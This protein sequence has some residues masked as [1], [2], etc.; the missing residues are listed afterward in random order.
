VRGTAWTSAQSGALAQA[1]EET[2][3][4]KE[5]DPAFKAHALQ[6]PVEQQIARDLGSS[7]DPDRIR[8]VRRQLVREIVARNRPALER[9]YLTNDSRLS[10]SP[11][12][13]QAGRRAM[14]NTALAQLVM[15]EA[16]GAAQ[17]AREQYQRAL[18]MTDRMSAL[19][20]IV[21]AW[22]ADAEDLLADFRSPFHRRSAGA[23]Q[24]AGAAGLGAGGWNG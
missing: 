20:T 24:V 12:F 5:L 11:D 18:N 4:S 13:Q 9:V 8:E 6:L 2:L 7:I 16:E 22:T 15:G 23:R 21:A 10:Y 14:K 17:L 19:G 3:N 1:L